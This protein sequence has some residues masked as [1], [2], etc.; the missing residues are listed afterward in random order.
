[1]TEGT[2][3][4]AYAGVDWA[5]EKHDACVVDPAGRVVAERAFPAD[6][7]GLAAMADLFERF[8]CALFAF[9]GGTI[10]YIVRRVTGTLIWAMVLHG[11]W[12]FSTFAVGHGTPGV[13]AGVGSVLYLV[14]MVVGLASVAFVIRGADERVLSAPMHAYPNLLAFGLAHV[15]RQAK[16]ERPT[17]PRGRRAGD[18]T[19]GLR[20]GTTQGRRGRARV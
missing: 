17:P 12:D 13:L 4:A 15:I 3:P 10:F 1:M 18:Q 6:A 8:V 9:G 5:T 16:H 14:A 19:S 2:S 20:R 7:A 11:L